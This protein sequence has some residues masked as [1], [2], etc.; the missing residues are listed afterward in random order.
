MR[1]LRSCVNGPVL[2]FLVEK[3]WFAFDPVAKVIPVWDDIYT[4]LYARLSYATKQ[5]E[6]ISEEEA[7]ASHVLRHTWN[8]IL[9]REWKSYSQNFNCGM[10]SNYS[11]GEHDLSPQVQLIVQIPDGSTV[12]IVKT[13]DAFCCWSAESSDYT[14]I[15]PIMSEQYEYVSKGTDGSWTE[16]EYYLPTLGDWWYINYNGYYIGNAWVYTHRLFSTDEPLAGT[17]TT[18]IEAIRWSEYDTE[19]QLFKDSGAGV[20]DIRFILMGGRHYDISCFPWIDYLDKGNTDAYDAYKDAM[21]AT[22]SEL[23]NIGD[24]LEYALYNT[25]YHEDP[26]VDS[27][28]IVSRIFGIGQMSNITDM[29]EKYRDETE[30]ITQSEIDSGLNYPI[31]G[32]NN[33]RLAIVDRPE[34]GYSLVLSGGSVERTFAG[35][36]MLLRYWQTYGDIAL[37]TNNAYFYAVD[38]KDGVVSGGQAITGDVADFLVGKNVVAEQEFPSLASDYTFYMAY[39]Q[40]PGDNFRDRHYL[41]DLT[42]ANSVQIA[43]LNDCDTFNF[44]L[45]SA[46]VFG[47]AL[48]PAELSA[49]IGQVEAKRNEIDPAGRM[50][51]PCMLLKK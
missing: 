46:N 12:S 15:N 42:K 23:V 9:Y 28:T 35:T 27:C 39:K 8:T 4:V 17:L 29:K 33:L 30:L 50:F 41:H 6:W 22:T 34:G 40:P 3:P 25:D 44:I 5:L 24:E 48:T 26:A 38:V 20:N 10:N 31:L 43:N 16:Y 37:P 49:V 32:T 18:T 36:F 7:G 19:S 13:L 51:S 47:I 21:G 2:A 11:E 1:K 45:D 14:I